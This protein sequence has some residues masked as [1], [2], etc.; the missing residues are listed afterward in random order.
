[1]IDRVNHPHILGLGQGQLQILVSFHLNYLKP[2]RI[3]RRIR[4]QQI[5]V[6]RYQ[7]MNDVLVQD[8][9]T[10]IAQRALLKTFKPITSVAHETVHRH[11]VHFFHYDMFAI[12][13]Y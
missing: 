13:H 5:L 6:Q 3:L 10:H 2:V 11:S 1:M 4:L 7:F 12:D 9:D 8:P